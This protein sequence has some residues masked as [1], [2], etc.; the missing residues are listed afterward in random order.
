MRK[1]HSRPATQGTRLAT[2]RHFQNTKNNV[3]YHTFMNIWTPNMEIYQKL[4][5]FPILSHIQQNTNHIK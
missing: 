1:R 4:T 2:T 3:K 5:V